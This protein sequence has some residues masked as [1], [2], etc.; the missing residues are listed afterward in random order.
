MTPPFMCKEPKYWY[1]VDRGLEVGI[2]FNKYVP[3]PSLLLRFLTSINRRCV[4]FVVSS[5][6][7]GHRV[8]LTSWIEA[9]A[10]YNDLYLKGKIVR[11]HC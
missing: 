6:P 8:R 2:F 1:V 10:L 11:V 7:G 3:P 9:A 4:D 5:V